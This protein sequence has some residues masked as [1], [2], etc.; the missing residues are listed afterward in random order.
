M[1][2][3]TVPTNARVIRWERDAYRE[4][5]RGNRFSKMI[6]ADESAA[7]QL[8]EELTKNA[9]E[10]MN[11]TLVNR[12]T[13]TGV[14]GFA[15]LEGNEE[16][17]GIRNFRV[18]VNR[19]RHAILHDKLSEQFSAINLVTS[20]RSVIMDWG[21]EN[22][23]DR[24]ITALGSI[25]IDGSTHYAYADAE[26]VAHKDVWLANNSDRVLFGAGVGSFTDHSA[27]IALLDTTN[28]IVNEANLKRLKDKAKAASPKVRPLKLND[29]EEWYV[30]VMGTRAFRAAQTALATLNREAWV[31]AKGDNNPLFTGG[32]L[33]MDGM[34]IKEVPE[35]GILAG[36]PGDGATTSV[37]PVYLMGA[38]AIAYAVAQR[39]KMISNERDYGAKL[40]AGVEMID[41][42]RKMY[43]GSGATDT[44]TPKQ[45]GV[46][47]GYFA[48]AA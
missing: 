45:H 12:A 41:A 48:L 25:S 19:T 30:V 16:A 7:I 34:I 10:Q 9:G 3:T 31:R 13:A 21:K 18:T 46:V 20:K 40:G 6:G 26:E 11:F 32:D 17:L 37:A 42:I 36:T 22:I 28:D 35:I 24:I 23:R 5:I 14:A 43:F 38:Q 39:S 4:F 15:T 1:A 27:D 47:T 2:E 8:N 33:I 29:E 44:T